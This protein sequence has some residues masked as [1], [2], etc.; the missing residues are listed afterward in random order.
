MVT[1]H[2]FHVFHI[3]QNILHFCLSNIK[4]YPLYFSSQHHY[5][6]MGNKYSNWILSSSNRWTIFMMTTFQWSWDMCWQLE[7]KARTGM[8]LFVYILIRNCIFNFT[9]WIMAWGKHKTTS[10]KYSVVHNMNYGICN[11]TLMHPPEA[12]LSYCLRETASNHESMA[13]VLFNNFLIQLERQ[14]SQEQNFLHRHNL[15]R[16]FHQIQVTD[17]H[18]HP[19]ISTIWCIPECQIHTVKKYS[20]VHL[21]E[22]TFP[23]FTLHV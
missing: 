10:L 9:F 21:Q 22:N 12:F 18:C 19:V 13:T 14:C 1:I 8:W 23:V 4:L 7:L 5:E 3:L 6:S 2:S 17:A 11:T 15:K 16:I 20:E